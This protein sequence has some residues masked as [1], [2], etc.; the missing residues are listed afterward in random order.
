MELRNPLADLMLEQYYVQY[1][2]NGCCLRAPPWMWA[3][4]MAA[5]AQSSEAAPSLPIVATIDGRQTAEPVSNYIFGMFIEHIRNTM[6]GPLWAEMLD[7]RKF[8]FPI[9]SKE[10]APEPRRQGG[11]P[12]RMPLQKWRPVGP[13]EVV[14]MD[15]DKPFVGEQSPRIELD[16]STPHGIRQSGLALVK[17]KRYMGRIVAARHAG[18]PAQRGARLGNGR[19]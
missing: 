15:K 11:G 17:G 1:S 6:Y 4:C 7:D 13:D 14:M 8:Y 10:E 16:A 3:G 18:Q 19:E 12:G 9:T 5:K 2:L